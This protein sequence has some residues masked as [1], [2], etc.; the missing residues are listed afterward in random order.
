VG[1][2]E[3]VRRAGTNAFNSIGTSMTRARYGA[4]LV[5]TTLVAVAGL[6]TWQIKGM[7]DNFG[8]FEQRMVKATSVTKTT[9]AEFHDMTIEAET[10]AKKW[11][12]PARDTADTFLFLGRAGLTAAQQLQAMPS[13]TAASKAMLEDLEQTTEGTVNVMNAFNIAFSETSHVT[14]M[15]TQAVNSSTMNL[16]EF[17]VSLSYAAEPAAAFNNTMADTAAM[18]GIAANAGIRGSKAGTALRYSL[19]QLAT[20]TVAMRGLLRELNIQVYGLGG[21]MRPLVDI[22]EEIQRKTAGYGEEMRNFTLKT[23]FGQRALSTMIALFA[24]GADGIRAYSAEIAGAVGVTAATAQKQMGAMKS[25]LEKLREAWDALKRHIVGA[26]S[27]NIVAAIKVAIDRVDEWTKK[28]DG[29]RE[30][31]LAL[32]K[33][34]AKMVEGFLVLTVKVAAFAVVAR[35]VGGLVMLMQALLSP[36]GKVLAGVF[37]LQSVW[38]KNFLHMRDVGH[39]VFEFLTEDVWGFVTT[40]INGVTKAVTY[41]INQLGRLGQ[42]LNMDKLVLQME[43]TLLGKYEGDVVAQETRDAL[44]KAFTE[45]NTKGLREGIRDTLIHSRALYEAADYYYGKRENMGVSGKKNAPPFLQELSTLVKWAKENP[46]DTIRDIIVPV[47]T[48]TQVMM[49]WMGDAGK[50]LKDTFTEDIDFI[51]KKF[52]GLVP[53]SVVKAMEEFKK[54]LGDM[55]TAFNATPAVER[56]KPT[57]PASPFPTTMP[58][59]QYRIWLE[60]PTSPIFMNRVKAV[61]RDVSG[62]FADN[63]NE[64]IQAVM[65]N[66][67][68]LSDIMIAGVTKVKDSIADA[69]EYLMTKGSS[70]VTFMDNVFQSILASFRRM[71]AEMAAN[72]MFNALFG[73]ALGR[74]T[75]G[76]YLGGDFSGLI[77]GFGNIFNIEGLVNYGTKQPP[78]T[79]GGGTALEDTVGGKIVV[80]RVEKITEGAREKVTEKLVERVKVV[81]KVTEKLVEMER[82]VVEKVIPFPK[83]GERGGETKAKTPNIVERIIQKVVPV[84]NTTI[85]TTTNTVEKIVQGVKEK[86]T[87]R[88]TERE[89]EIVE[90]II[91]LPS[92]GVGEAKAKTPNIVEKVIQKVVPVANTFTRNTINNVERIKN[93]THTLTNT[94]NTHTLTD[95]RVIEKIVPFKLPDLGKLVEGVREGGGGG[96]A[97]APSVSIH[98]SNNGKPVELKQ[99]GAV[100][101]D[102]RQVVVNYVMEEAISN[103]RFREILMGGV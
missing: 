13:V 29:A 66:Y 83:M 95:T 18:L 70:F 23:L 38:T 6:M 1:A 57:V 81:P 91:P 69:F 93:I 99:V 5:A 41:T 87:E 46:E 61:V 33:D 19:T 40:L 12:E 77:R 73:N 37:M 51:V 8:E 11:G 76:Y 14:D 32:A 16:H 101:F 89:H 85:Q 43:L 103:P 44:V 21:K 90:R 54:L 3:T 17:L 78:R 71:V 24:K 68:S 42:N 52:T 34:L 25:Q 22:I 9:K 79:E 72:T 75:T 63:W 4:Q 98:V 45:N 96:G 86:V 48:G 94:T 60:G 7:V 26:F 92:T 64:A 67:Q 31:V 97:T 74:R 58:V 36:L 102:G 47:K 84:T 2:F 65:T 82:E 53:D 50:A 39:A 15:M 10:A 59:D 28:L 80:E 56:T 88:L 35:V 20:P 27:A 62:Y 49:D 55:N 100:K 30:K